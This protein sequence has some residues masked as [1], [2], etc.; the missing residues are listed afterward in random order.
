MLEAIVFAEKILK[1]LCIFLDDF[2]AAAG[3]EKLPLPEELPALTFKDQVI[4]AAE[5]L[6]ADA[7][8]LGDKFA[9]S[10]AVRKVKSQLTEQFSKQIE[11]Y[12]ENGNTVFSALLGKIQ[13]KIMRRSIIEEGRRCDSRSPEDIRP[14]ST[15]ID[16]LPRAHGSSLF[17]RGETQSI[18]IVTLGSTYDEQIFDDIDGDRR[19][20]SRL[21]YHLPPSPR[22]E[23]G[24]P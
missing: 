19:P 24:R 4:S 8:F 15:E 9:R 21:P 2:A 18:G 5:P 7:V 16:L 14:I 23:T 1:D 11:E 12:G 3:K 6:F 22:G 13:T 10:N 20:T 17:T